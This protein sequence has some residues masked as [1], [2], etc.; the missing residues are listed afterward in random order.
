[1]K[2]KATPELGHDYTTKPLGSIEGSLSSSLSSMDLQLC[3]DH[4]VYSACRPPL[5]TVETHGPSP[6]SWLCPVPLTC[7][8]SRD[9]YLC[10]LQPAA[11]G[12][13]SQGPGED[14]FITKCQMLGLLDSSADERLTDNTDAQIMDKMDRQ[15]EGA[16]ER[17]PCS[18]S[19][20]HNSPSPP[21]WQN[22]TSLSPMAFCSPF[23]PAL[24]SKDPPFCFPPF[25]STY[26]LFLP[27][28]YLFPY[29]A[30]PPVQCTPLFMLSQDTS[31]PTVAT[32]SLL[33]AVSEPG[34]HSVQGEPLLPHLE[35]YQALCQPQPS[36]VQDAGPGAARSYL[37]ELEH[38]ISGAPAKR[39]HP[40]SRAVTTVLP[41]PLKKENGRILYECN[42]C[43]KSFGQLSNL[44]VHLRVHSGERPFQC[45]LCLKSFTQLAHLQKH[46]LV[47]TGERPHKCPMCHK[48][49]SSSSNLKTH[50]RLHSGARPFQCSLC[51][52]RF[53]QY[54]HLKLHHRL[55][56]PQHHRLAYTHLPLASLTC[57]TQWHQE[58]LDFVAAPSKR[59][60]ASW[61]MDKVKVSLASQG[62][63]ELPA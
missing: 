51:P 37:P 58:A 36:Q 56:T 18:S 17:N 46:H 60:M 49:F 27:P 24:L 9:L 39:A 10:T 6:G 40:G 42:E 54:V 25:Y 48:R 50:L 12:T 53:T 45:T 43:G 41:Y 63:P 32:P 57:L 3:Q 23:L 29:R 8:Q 38:N 55:H 62:K 20:L 22:R 11:V 61:T 1:M 26:P 28:P 59:Q 15:L 4:Q 35:I 31:H 2:E 19:P 5:D 33:R 34:H 30:L 21:P 47:H 14:S 44:K 13:P 16:G 7:P 52:S